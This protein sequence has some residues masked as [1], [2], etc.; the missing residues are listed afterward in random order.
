MENLRVIT[1]NLRIGF[2]FHHKLRYKFE[3]GQRGNSQ[4]HDYLTTSPGLQNE[5]NKK[6]MMNKKRRSVIIL[7]NGYVLIL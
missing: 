2:F 1:F 4:L 5:I 7:Q 6:T 3:R